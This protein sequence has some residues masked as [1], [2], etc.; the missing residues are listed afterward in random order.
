MCRRPGPLATSTQL[1]GPLATSTQLS[2]LAAKLLRAQSILDDLESRKAA[3]ASVQVSSSAKKSKTT[4]VMDQ[5][6]N[7]EDLND[8]VHGTALLES[9]TTESTT[10][11]SALV[12]TTPMCAMA[13]LPSLSPFGVRNN[14]TGTT[15]T[16]APMIPMVVTTQGRTN[17]FIRVNCHH[18]PPHLPLLHPTLDALLA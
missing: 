1:S 4:A 10:T 14:T 9:S 6:P 12:S 11:T 5:R 17:Y 15:V 16:T 2:P 18:S 13:G 7:L 8:L 3:N